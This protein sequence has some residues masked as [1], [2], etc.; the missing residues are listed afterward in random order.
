LILI[1]FLVLFVEPVETLLATT[2]VSTLE[3]LT[4]IFGITE[5]VTPV[6]RDVF[7]GLR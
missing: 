4:T 3:V 7:S 2:I 1:L 5:E 6:L